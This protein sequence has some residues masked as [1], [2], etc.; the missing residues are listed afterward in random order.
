MKNVN[1]R[2]K[3]GATV[4]IDKIAKTIV[5]SSVYTS[6]SATPASI[7]EIEKPAFK[8]NFS[9]KFIKDVIKK[10][11]IKNLISVMAIICGSPSKLNRLKTRLVTNK[12]ITKNGI[13]IND[14]FVATVTNKTGSILGNVSIL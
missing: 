12:D 9:E 10:E 6:T 1:I 8:S 2:Y 3:V 13:K 4:N 11:K 5:Q 14:A 7:F